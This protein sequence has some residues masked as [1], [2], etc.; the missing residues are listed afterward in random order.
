ML[1]FRLKPP[2][3]QKAYH[4]EYSMPSGCDLHARG[5]VSGFWRRQ[6]MQTTARIVVSHVNLSKRDTMASALP[7][8]TRS[9]SVTVQLS[10]G[11]RWRRTKN[12]RNDDE[13]AKPV[14]TW[15]RPADRKKSRDR[16]AKQNRPPRT[17]IHP[18][19]RAAA[20]RNARHPSSDFRSRWRSRCPLA[21]KNKIVAADTEEWSPAA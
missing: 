14:S 19:R 10:G 21:T 18:A 9:H 15:R 6:R 20:A 17:N 2:R 7:C 4:A 13:D 8:R 12:D 11:R 5:Q 16:H 3:A 1:V